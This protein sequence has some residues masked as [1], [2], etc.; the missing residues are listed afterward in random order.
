MKL[1]SAYESIS[2]IDSIGVVDEAVEL[3]MEE[4]CLGEALAAILM[5]F[6]ANDMEG[7]VATVNSLLGLVSYSYQPK[8]LDLDLENRKAPPI[9]LSIKESPKLELK[10]IPSYLRRVIGWTIADIRGIPSGICEHK[11]QLEEDSIPSVEHQRRLNPPMQE[12]VKKETIKWL[13]AGVVY[14]IAD[15]KWMSPV[16][17]VSKKR[18]ITVVS[19]AKNKLI[20]T[21]TVTGWRDAFWSLQ[22]TPTFQRCMM[23]IFSDIVE[24]Y[25]EVF[26]DGFYVIGDSFDECLDHL[27]PLPKRCEETN[28][29]LNWEKGHFTVNEGIVLSHKISEKGIEVDQAKINVISK[30][31]QPIF[32]KGVRSFLGHASFYRHFIKNFSKVANPMCKLL[33]KEAKFVFDEKYRKEFDELKERLTSAPIIVSPDWSLPF[34]LMCDS[35]GFAIGVVLG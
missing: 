12:V 7:Y 26:M 27:C 35:S 34:E 9:K 33:E 21:R 32:L 22:C 14:P 29:V 24:D 16:Q 3:T 31:P 28:L 8:K 30:L 6:D 11:I 4:K 18:G 10:H 5:N 20:S 13:N 19:N 25:L 23:S 2:F 1:P 15:S 17:S